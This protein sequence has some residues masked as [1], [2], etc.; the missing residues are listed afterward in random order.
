M[1][2]ISPSSI[3]STS[4]GE[5]LRRSAGRARRKTANAGW[6]LA[7]VGTCR[8]RRALRAPRIRWR[9]SGRR[10][11]ARSTRPATAAS[12]DARPPST[13]P[14]ARER[15]CAP[16]RRGSAQAPPARRGSASRERRHSS[17]RSG[18]CSRSV[19]R[20][21]CSALFAAID[22]HLQHR[23]GLARAPPDHVAQDQHRP[24]PRRQPLDR[25]EK[26]SSIVSARRSPVRGVLTVHDLSSSLSGYG[27]S[28]VTS[29]VQQRI[30]SAG[31]RRLGRRLCGNSRRD[32][33]SSRSSDRSSRSR[34]A[35]RATSTCPRKVSRRRQAR[36]NV[37]WTTSSASSAEPS[38]R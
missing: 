7:R 29:P 27:S 30:C 11:H 38:I 18:R 25:D 12:T 2:A 36:R 33:R 19:S 37:S 14:R 15:R 4:I 24:L 8:C 32:R 28:H 6:R 1:S 34:T 13:T 17:R 10:H 31:V 5:R 3:R 21:R 26:A 16:T 23:R 22:R 9:R 20:A 35:T